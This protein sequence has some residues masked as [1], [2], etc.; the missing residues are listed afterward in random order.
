MTH[1]KAVANG[2][3]LESTV[4]V[5]QTKAQAPTGRGLDGGEGRG[6]KVARAEEEEEDEGGWGI[7]E[8]G[9]LPEG[10]VRR[11]LLHRQH[12]VG[13]VHSAGV[14]WLASQARL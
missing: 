6:G 7:P 9:T 4:T 2:R 11:L 5:R 10:G 3:V 13:I 12:G 14:V 1:A 8:G